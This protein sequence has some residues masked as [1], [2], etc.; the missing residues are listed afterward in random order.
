[1]KRWRRLSRR[2]TTSCEGV[3]SGRCMASAEAGARRLLNDEL[4]NCCMALDGLRQLRLTEAF[5]FRDLANSLAFLADIHWFGHDL[6]PNIL[7]VQYDR[8]NVG[9]AES[10]NSLAASTRPCPATICASLLMRTGLLKPNLRML[11]AICSI[12]FLE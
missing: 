7:F 3:H 1:M 2:K 9:T 8:R 11:A 6:I 10:P 4:G 12:C 5:V